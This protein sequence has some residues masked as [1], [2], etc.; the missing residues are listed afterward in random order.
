MWGEEKGLLL[1][2]IDEKEFS[3]FLEKFRLFLKKVVDQLAV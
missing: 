1:K 3:E 2:E